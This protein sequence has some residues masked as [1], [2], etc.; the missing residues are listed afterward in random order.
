VSDV[1][2]EIA[3]P[4]VSADEAFRA[5][6]QALAAA[7]FELWKTRPL[8]RFAIA[9][10]PE[11]AST[12]EANL[13]VR[14]GEPA[15]ITLGLRGEDLTEMALASVASEILDGAARAVRRNAP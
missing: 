8:G 7:G 1:R 11:G 6:L 2:R 4:K 14:A 9:R 10:R 3:L 13:S 12:L 5:G 15:Q